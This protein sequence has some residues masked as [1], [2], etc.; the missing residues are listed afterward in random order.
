MERKSLFAVLLALLILTPAVFVGSGGQAAAQSAPQITLKYGELNPDS[1]PMTIAAKEFAKNVADLS[2][3]R[4]KI[5]IYAGGQLG[6]EKNMAQLVQIGGGG[7]DMMRIGSNTLGDFGVGQMNILSLPYIF[8]DR[9][10]MWDVL[11]SKIG[12]DL[13]KTIAAKDSTKMVGLMYFDEGARHFFFTKK[14]VSRI[15]DMKGLKIRVPETQVMMDMVRAFG[16]SPTP[17]S[18][19]ELYSSLQTG[20]VDGAENPL[21]GYLANNFYENGKYVTLDGHTYAPSVLVISQKTWATLSEA[22]HQ[23]LIQAAKKTQKFI[24]QQAEANDQQAMAAIKAKGGIITEVADK[25]EWQKAVEPLFVKYGAGFQDLIQK[26][27][28]TK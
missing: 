18:Y 4:I 1:H 3:G 19:S 9:N 26:I 16:A 6:D 5:D 20:V 2:G 10:Q 24:K 7:L 28:D 21:T 13:L 17:I 12:E 11:E 14:K 23:V 15:A 22:D 25:G 8:R 27:R